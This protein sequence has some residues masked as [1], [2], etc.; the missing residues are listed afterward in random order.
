M[1]TLIPNA[2]RVIS[3]S[4]MQE[5]IQSY[6]KAVGTAY[7]TNDVT[8]FDT[9][10]QNLFTML[11]QI[12]ARVD[13][14]RDPTLDLSYC[15]SCIRYLCLNVLDDRNLYGKLKDVGINQ[16]GNDRKHD[17][18]EAGG[19]DSRD[20]A[21][22]IYNFTVA[23]IRDMYKL[24]SLQNLMYESGGFY[25]QEAA[26]EQKK[27]LV[28][29]ETPRKTVPAVRSAVSAPSAAVSAA[30]PSPAPSAVR[31]KEPVDISAAPQTKA[32]RFSEQYV[33]YLLGAIGLFL[34]VC[35]VLDRIGKADAPDQHL[36]GWIGFHLC[37]FLYGLFGGAAFLLPVVHF[38]MAFSWRRYC[39]ER[40]VILQVILSAV[41][42]VLIAGFIHV[43]LCNK[44]PATASLVN[45]GKLYEYGPPFAGGRSAGIIGG[46]LGWLMFKGLKF[47]G[48][49]VL[50]IIVM[51]LLTMFLVGVTPAFVFT[52]LKTQFAAWRKAR[53]ERRAAEEELRKERGEWEAAQAAQAAQ[54]SAAGQ[55]ADK[56]SGADNVFEGHAARARSKEREP[57]P[58]AVSTD[59]A[60]VEAR[61]IWMDPETGEV[62]KENGRPTVTVDAQK[63]QAR[64]AAARR[65]SSVKKPTPIGQHPDNDLSL[66]DLT[67][68]G[69]SDD[70]SFLSDGDDEDRV[71]VMTDKSDLGFE[72]DARSAGQPNTAEP[73]DDLT[74]DLDDV[75][76][77]DDVIVLPGPGDTA[78]EEDDDDPLA[79]LPIRPGTGKPAGQ[80]LVVRVIKSDPSAL[81]GTPD[82]PVD[83][84]PDEQTV[85]RES[86]PADTAA[87]AGSDAPAESAPAPYVY[88]PID[89]LAKG[90]ATYEADPVE[91]AKNTRILR[92]TLES[93]RIGVR[94][95]SCSCGP[96][97]T[98]FEVKPETGVRVRAITNLVDDIALNLAKSG[99]RIE[100]PIPGKSA[101]GIEVPNDKPATVYLRNLLET[102]EFQNHKSRLAACLGAEVSGKPI[103]FDINK[104]PHLLVS[105]TT[106]SGKSVCINCIILSLL[107]KATPQ[108]VQLILIDPKK[109]EFNMYRNIPHLKTPIVTNPKK[110]AGALYAAV[111]EMEWRFNLIEQVGVR[112][113]AGYNE[114]TA[115]DPEH[116]PLPQLV[117]IIDELAD[118]M[119]T[120][121]TDV[122]N[123]ICRLA[124][125]GRAAG[126]HLILGTQRPSVD[127]ITGLIKAN[128]PSR[129]AFTV[130]SQIDSRT[131]ID[132]VGAEKLIGRGD[133][134]YAPVGSVKPLRVQGAFVSDS[135]V[136]SVVDFIKENN[137]PPEFSE[138]FADQID[139]EAARCG[140]GKK[141]SDD[142]F[143]S[144][145]DDAV[146]G[147][148]DED[149]KFWEALEVAVNAEK[150][151]TS[152]LQRRAN[153]G[154]GR[155]AK[156]IDRM[157]D[158]GFVGP[159]DGNKP[160]KLLITAQEFAELK[161]NGFKK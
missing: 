137:D 80:E 25:R 144:A 59:R 128:I 105:G 60:A 158:L 117:I 149:A 66:D 104:M 103:I 69:A 1:I 102:P 120:A 33:P 142:S 132:V 140:A 139:M 134:L 71:F 7:R 157:E 159:A 123:A 135:E 90:S 19:G 68:G 127:V 85:S 99:V 35:L 118:L 112:N 34:A 41:F 49:L 111:E 48:S 78:G 24:P 88:P 57:N 65:R 116:P 46:Y 108:E 16:N 73:E 94:E 18:A 79:D 109:V 62:L 106:G 72:P 31:T 43:C 129:I 146:G 6:Y 40:L 44:D 8:Q 36:M 50:F 5:N 82:N 15:K 143:G 153:I 148:G 92:D 147:D 81:T 53:K 113:L 58:K 51:P 84:L 52:L 150:V 70:D 39:R 67:V 55:P 11:G 161:M 12:V 32:Q 155:A 91:V 126:I 29:A 20:K 141:K 121:P 156:I 124:Q 54:A 13:A 130:K 17:S 87:A 56:P 75:A 100:A 61:A 26:A 122:E 76:D 95:I 42:I 77:P 89:L 22:L 74:I 131:I 110:A 138:E 152:L 125:K 93:F 2:D 86:A 145:S 119:M 107:Y 97:V 3:D 133:M 115:G 23:S 30:T 45:F 37:R 151:S 38:M 101:V 83:G 63:D 160:R 96:T 10:M 136:E 114:V 28:P 64:E 47:A 14:G 27:T 9:N 4:I 154:Y 98:R 21:I